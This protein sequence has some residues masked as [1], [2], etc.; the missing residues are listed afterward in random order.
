[1]SLPGEAS[2]IML[3]SAP[4]R[5]CAP[6]WIAR[7]AAASA[8]ARQWKPLRSPVPLPDLGNIVGRIDPLLAEAAGAAQ[9][10]R[11]QDEFHREP[12]ADHDVVAGPI[13]AD[14]ARQADDVGR[15]A[16]GARLGIFHGVLAA[17]VL[18][19]RSEHTS[20]SHANDVW[21]DSIPLLNQRFARY[22]PWRPC[23]CDRHCHR[24]FKAGNDE[25]VDDSA[26]RGWS[27]SVRLRGEG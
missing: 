18:R 17:L 15:P 25:A 26:T 27:H 14:I 12:F 8:P 19:Y 10:S 11:H 24:R 3:S 13:A 20:A 22:S 1:M 6:L 5:T 2:F 16:F 7:Q 9:I 21:N 23:Q 4:P